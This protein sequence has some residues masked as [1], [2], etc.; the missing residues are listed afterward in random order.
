MTTLKA[1]IISNRALI[2]RIYSVLSTKER[3][4]IFVSLLARLFLVGLDLVGIALIGAVVGMLSGTHIS[5]KSTFGLIVRFIEERGFENAYA[6]ILAVAV[7]FFIFKGVLS[8]LLNRSTALYISNIEWHQAIKVFRRLFSQ[9]LDVL[10]GSTRESIIFTTTH[11]VSSLTTKPLLIMTTIVSEVA[12]LIAISIYL[13]LANWMLFL[14]IAIFFSFVGWFMHRFVTISSGVAA[15]AVHEANLE[16]QGIVLDS[17]ANSRQGAL[18]PNFESVIDKFS[19]SR[20]RFARQ[21]AI[22]QTITGLPRYI[23]EISVLLGIGILVL[24]RALSPTEAPSASV[25]ALFLAG[26]FRLVS[27]MIPLQSALTL[28]KSIQFE[29][30]G[31]SVVLTEMTDQLTELKRAPSNDSQGIEIEVAG[32]GFSYS[33]ANTEALNDIT[34]QVPGG[35]FVAI[36]GKSG[37]GKSTLADLLLGLREPRRG[38]ILLNGVPARSFVMENKG[39][40]GYVPQMSYIYSGTLR[41]NVSLNFGESVVGED[42]RVR[43]VLRKVGLTKFSEYAPLGLDTFLGDGG[44]SVS[45]G[46]AQRISLARA[47]FTAPKLLVLD[48]AT[49]ALDGQTQSIVQ[50]AILDLLGSTTIVAIAHREETVAQADYVIQIAGGKV[51]QAR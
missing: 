41:Q 26:I 19:T 51:I 12:L 47:L 1:T 5:P 28:W 34:F 6:V 49:S 17:L 30:K 7:A 35:A 2:S 37:G 33:E 11:S 20:K 8:A 40:V 42:D 38:Q 14:S 48:E 29:S 44:V 23:T 13:A 50:E 15:R 43:D 32:L 18:S 16:S 21:G 9:T 22:Y 10:E 46:E 31:S 4:L 27:S 3:V 24:E 36:I 39:A 45:G 25:I